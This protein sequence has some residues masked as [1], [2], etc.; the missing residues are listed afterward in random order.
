MILI[1]IVGI[2][3]KLRC[4][5]PSVIEACYKA[6]IN[7]RMITG[8]NKRTAIAVAKESGLLDD[9]WYERDDDCTVMEGR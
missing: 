4:E 1:A 2:K 5:I 6:G 8:D 7:V 9:K 3:D